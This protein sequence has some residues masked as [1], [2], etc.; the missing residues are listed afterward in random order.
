MNSVILI[1][2]M[3]TGKTVVGK[4]LAERLCMKFV[5]LDVLI[6]EKMGMSIG[7]IFEGFGESHF[8]RIEREVVS[9]VTKHKAGGDG[10]VIATGGG[11]VLDSRNVAELKN[12][13]TLIHLCARPGVILKRT[14]GTHHRPLL[15]RENRERNIQRLLREREALY[16][17]S[18]FEIDTSDL[19]VEEIV[20][21]I[22]RYLKESHDGPGVG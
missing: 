17:R 11:V 6:E 20:E 18:D 22:V 16:S 15:E 14:E 19:E 7:E 21:K 8:R 1:G 3:G 10:L 2:F 9:Q 4:R 13:G 12:M 5:G